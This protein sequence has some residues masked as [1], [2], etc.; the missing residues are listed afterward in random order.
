MIRSVSEIRA[1]RNKI[2]LM[3]NYSDDADSVRVDFFKKSGKWYT[4][5]AVKWTGGYKD[6]LIHRAY[7][8]SLLE[9]LTTHDGRLRLD[10]MVAICLEPYHEHSC[11]M[12][13]NVADAKKFGDIE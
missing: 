5:E 1:K 2:I 7:A 13:M 9:H 4:T 6:V 3:G 12:M 11:P 10:D 8:K